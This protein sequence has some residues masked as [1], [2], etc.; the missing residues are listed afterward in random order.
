MPGGSRGT[1]RSAGPET[2]K[3]S[4]PGDPPQRLR[5]GDELRFFRDVV[6]DDATL[7]LDV[8]GHKRK[9]ERSHRETLQARTLRDGPE[10]DPGWHSQ[11]H[12]QEKEVVV[13]E[14][15]VVGEKGH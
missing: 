1:G 8:A 7:L 2:T 5:S 6:E 10:R 13:V 4:G 9:R 14:R 11:H 3:S 15:P 12:R